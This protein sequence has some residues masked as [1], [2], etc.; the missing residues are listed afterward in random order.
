MA[1]ITEEQSTEENEDVSST[2][3]ERAEERL[4]SLLDDATEPEEKGAEEGA[5][6]EEKTEGEPE[7]KDE[8]LSERVA[9]IN[10]QMRQ[11]EQE[12]QEIKAAKHELSLKEKEVN[13]TL[14]IVANFQDEV[15]KDPVSAFKRLGLDL[16]SFIAQPYGEG[17]EVPATKEPDITKTF[18]E[19]L[20]AMEQRLLGAVEEKLETVKTVQKEEQIQKAKAYIYRKIDPEK[21]PELAAQPQEVTEALFNQAVEYKKRYGE[22]MDIDEAMQALEERVHKQNIELITR[23]AKDERYKKYFSGETEQQKTKPA[24]TPI[25]G[26]MTNESVPPRKPRTAEERLQAAIALAESSDLKI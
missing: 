22:I 16:M 8:L 11:L 17:A 5:E 13:E 1:D 15:K 19:R 10:T 20:T 4:N 26:T 21:Y 3:E 2:P 25:T 23:A 24:P 18:E 9:H 7:D 6:E 14:D 12:R